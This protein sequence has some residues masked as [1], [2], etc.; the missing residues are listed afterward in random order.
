MVQKSSHATIAAAIQR[1]G[2]AS[3][4]MARNVA[5]WLSIFS[6]LLAGCSAST[7][8]KPEGEDKD[9]LSAGEIQY[10]ITKSGKKYEF[11]KPP[12]F[13]EETIAGEAKVRVAEGVLRTQVLIPL[14]DVDQVSVK[15]KEH[16]QSWGRIGVIVAGIAALVLFIAGMS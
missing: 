14:S 5:A 10:V 13:Y 4:E 6:A 12:A 1:K 11:E 3:M 16:D 15:A 8:V 7:M 2:G 9:L